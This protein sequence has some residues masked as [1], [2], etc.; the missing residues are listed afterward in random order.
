MASMAAGALDDR[1][2]LN[3]SAQANRAGTARQPGVHPGQHLRG[4]ARHLPIPTLEHDAGGLAHQGL[5]KPAHTRRPA[6]PGHVGVCRSQR[7]GRH[8]SLAYRPGRGQDVLG[9]LP[10]L[11]VP[12]A[13]IGRFGVIGMRG[14]QQRA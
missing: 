5:L 9:G 3:I 13:A 10:R 12:A 6:V 14:A 8:A 2:S 4:V 1:V 11:V 7:K